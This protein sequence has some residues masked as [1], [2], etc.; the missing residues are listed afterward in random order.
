MNFQSNH[1]G[2]GYG[3][4]GTS[5]NNTGVPGTS[6]NG[7]GVFGSSIGGEGVHGETNST[8]FAAVVG[9]A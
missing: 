3:V 7:A 5:L 9:V 1:D 2:A 4:K 8:A 6:N